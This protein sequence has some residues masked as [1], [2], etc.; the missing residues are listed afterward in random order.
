MAQQTNAS[1]LRQ[2]TNQ[3]PPQCKHITIE[4]C[5]QKTNSMLD[6]K[7]LDEFSPWHMKRC[8][9]LVVWRLFNIVT[10]F[11]VEVIVVV[12]TKWKFTQI[13]QSNKTIFNSKDFT[14]ATIRIQFLQSSSFRWCL[15]CQSKD[16]HDSIDPESIAIVELLHPSRIRV[17]IRWRKELHENCIFVYHSNEHRNLFSY[18]S[19]HMSSCHCG[20]CWN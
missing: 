5:K 7:T 1:G 19:K 12:L 3:L 11:I 2:C 4:E 17:C 16:S 13:V 9:E 18:V 14:L 10:F 6:E 8:S 15:R 20:H